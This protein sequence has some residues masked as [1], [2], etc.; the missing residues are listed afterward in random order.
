MAPPSSSRGTRP[1]S[2]PN[3]APR[4][5]KISALSRK[6]TR[7]QIVR[8]CRRDVGPTAVERLCCRY[9]PPATHASTADTCSDSAAD[10][11]TYGPAS[12]SSASASGSF[13]E[14]AR[15]DD[16][17]GD[18]QPDEAA[19]AGVDEEADDRLAPA[20]QA[21][22]RGGDGGAIEHERRRVVHEALAFE[23][24]DHAPRNRK[25]RDD[26]RGGDGIG[27]RDDG[28]ECD[29]DGP[30]ESGKEMPRR[31][32]RRPQWWRSRVRS[33]AFRSCRGSA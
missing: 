33:R 16:Q 9:T 17:P 7:S 23:H 8:D 24:G 15:A 32:S 6:T 28:A 29:R 19:D 27:R 22:D 1:S 4:R 14:R 5:R 26:R 3:C 12:V 30:W 11:A 13:V 31:R 10:H 25:P 21:R 18:E 2:V 20:E